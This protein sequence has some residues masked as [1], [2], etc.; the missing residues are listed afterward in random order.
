MTRERGFSLVEVVVAILILTVGVLGLAASAGTITRLTAEGGR[1]GA[2]AAV[3]EARF[4][5]LRAT[6]C[7]SLASGSATS[8]KFTETWRITSPTPLLRTVEVAVSYSHGR[9]TRTLTFTSQISCA[10]SV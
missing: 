7:A 2:A 9:G 10:P 1:A 3:A 6:D 4:E 5:R 8:G